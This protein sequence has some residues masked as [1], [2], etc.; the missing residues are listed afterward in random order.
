MRIIYPN[1]A[2]DAINSPIKAPRIQKLA[3]N[4]NDWIIQ[5]TDAGKDNNQNICFLL[6]P[7]T[8]KYVFSVTSYD[9]DIETAGSNTWAEATATSTNNR[10]TLYFAKS[11]NSRTA[12]TDRRGIAI[13]YDL[14][15]GVNAGWYVAA[16][17]ADPTNYRNYITEVY[18]NDYVLTVLSSSAITL[19]PSVVTTTTFSVRAQSGEA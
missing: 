13:E 16:K 9:T 14:T 17:L 7:F 3:F 11:A 1:P 5:S 18:G 15:N 12:V 4:F 2:S 10:T 8:S 19:T 6:A